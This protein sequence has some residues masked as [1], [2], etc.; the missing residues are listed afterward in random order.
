MWSTAVQHTPFTH[1]HEIAENLGTCV[2]LSCIGIFYPMHA[3]RII[4]TFVKEYFIHMQEE[5]NMCRNRRNVFYQNTHR[6][7]I[8]HALKDTNVQDMFL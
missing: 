3:G 4:P 7:K 8:K 6:K 1:I 2:F 5:I